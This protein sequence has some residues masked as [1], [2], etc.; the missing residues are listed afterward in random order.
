[1][2]SHERTEK[3]R[4][5]IMRLNELLGLMRARITEGERAYEAL[6]AGINKA[7]TVGLSHKEVQWKVAEQL[8]DLAPLKDAVGMLRFGS[9]ELEK[10][11][12]ELYDIIDGTPESMEWPGSG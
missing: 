8:E 2:S 12:A 5:E 6:F 3:V 4:Q 10:A 1:M 11:F 9:R 7:E